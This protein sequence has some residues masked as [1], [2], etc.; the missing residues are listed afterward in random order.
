[1]DILFVDRGVYVLSGV[2]KVE[3]EV[4]AVAGM[5]GSFVVIGILFES[6][7]IEMVESA[8]ASVSI[9]KIAL[10]NVVIDVVVVNVA[11]V[12][13]VTVIFVVI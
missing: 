5:G 7:L 12:G 4:I 13:M 3:L 6:E 8:D 10:S 9:E 1:M 2:V 11:T